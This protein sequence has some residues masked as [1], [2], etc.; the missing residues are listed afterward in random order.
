MKAQVAGSPLVI[1]AVAHAFIV[2]ILG[3]SIYMAY[4]VTDEIDRR[5]E[6]AERSRK[7][8]PRKLSKK[9]IEEDSYSLSDVRQGWGTYQSSPILKY[10]HE[11]DSYELVRQDSFGGEGF[12]ET[13][14]H[15]V[16][17]VERILGQREERKENNAH[18][19]LNSL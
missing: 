8:L 14:E 3:P 9:Y 19:F 18:K 7:M 15:E 4:R 10:N 2:L 13:P 12:Q 6:L 17:R 1:K 11:E 16:V 5:R